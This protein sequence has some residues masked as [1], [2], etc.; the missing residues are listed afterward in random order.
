M[1]PLPA[2]LQGEVEAVTYEALRF[3]W[4]VEAAIILPRYKAL[5]LS[6][7]GWCGGG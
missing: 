4:F 2:E 3:V 7:T 5:L 1:D 6:D